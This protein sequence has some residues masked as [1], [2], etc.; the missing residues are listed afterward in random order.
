[1]GNRFKIVTLG[2]KVNQYE[3]AYL[4]EK[5]LEA[6]WTPAGPGESGDLCIV[7]TCIVTQKAA[8]QSRQEI[9]KAIRET[10]GGTIV[11]TGCYPQVYGRELLDIEGISLVCGNT[12]KGRLPRL[13]LDGMDSLEKIFQREDFTPGMPFEFLQVGQFSG[14]AR[15]YLK[16]QDGCESFCS[17][18]IV[19]LARGPMRSLTPEKVLSQMESLAG[20]G[21]REV[22]LTG[23]HL[24][25]YGID[26]GKGITLYRLL[27][28]IGKEAYPLRVRLSSIEP[29]ELGAGL[30]ELVASE[31]WLCRHFH[32]PLQ[33]GDEETLKKMN[34]HYTPQ[35]FVQ[36]IEMLYR[37]VP[38]G[39]IGVD[40][41]AGFPGE[42][43]VSHQNTYSL[44]KD[45]PVSYLHV[46][47][48][49][50]RPGTAAFSFDG[51][52]DPKTVK[53]RAEKLRALGRRKRIAFYRSCLNREFPVL[54]EGWQHGE[55][56]TM[57][58]TSDNY[59]P[60]VFTALERAQNRILPV[61]IEKVEQER[62]L[63]RAISSQTSEQA[64]WSERD[65]ARMEI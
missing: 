9:R 23:I 44:I 47:P 12:V 53:K 2:C 37:T 25:K 65:L 4:Q 27:R 57:K 34:R 35:D 62:V 28:F 19:P 11:V 48:F 20:E 63:G 52:V 17:Y 41:M 21:Y 6:G 43:S 55:K 18:C 13:L 32:V 58:G 40:V 36:L 59:L 3:S 60:V 29:K 8:H 49:S 46:F 10:P 7:N 33:S 38:H 30:V 31:S 14:R 42:D 50:A 22:V 26:L 15:A 51:Q 45:L 39:A 54:P 1:M 24:G 5:F 61:R 56:G 16:I 64:H